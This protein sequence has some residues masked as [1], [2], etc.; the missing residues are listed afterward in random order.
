M[1]AALIMTLRRLLAG[2][3]SR[4]DN[5]RLFVWAALALVLYLGYA[6]WQDDYAPRT[7]APTTSATAPSTNT[8]DGRADTLPTLPAHTEGTPQLSPTQQPAAGAQV[9]KAPTIRVITDVLDMDIST[10]GGELQRADLLKYP[11]VKGQP[12]PVRMFNLE[13]LFVARS[14]LRAAD[15]EQEPTHLATFTAPAQEFRLKD[16]E[17]K[18]EVPLTWTDGNGVTVTKIYTFEP[19][20]YRIGLRYEVDN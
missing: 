7:P 14:G 20:S 16:G 4:M 12:D 6:A 15:R 9:E 18:L 3:L 8:T 11:K 10:R 2:T 13:N 17:S 1:P 19:G 5:Q